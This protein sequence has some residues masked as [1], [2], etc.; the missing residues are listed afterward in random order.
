MLCK[1]VLKLK[2]VVSVVTNGDLVKRFC[3][4]DFREIGLMVK[5]GEDIRDQRHGICVV[6]SDRV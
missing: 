4:I 1:R 3:K 2:H 5:F 6:H